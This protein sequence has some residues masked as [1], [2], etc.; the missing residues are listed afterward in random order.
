M[1]K[2]PDKEYYSPSDFL[3]APKYDAHIHY[4]TFDDSFVRK[5]SKANI[6]LLSINT[7]FNVPIDTQFEV[8][9]SLHQ[10]HP[11]LFNFLCTFDASKFNAE[12]FAEDSIER[13]KLCVAAG[14]KGVKM[15]KNIGMILKNEVGKY[16]MADDPVFEPIFRYLE[17]EKIPLLA[18]FGDTRNCWLPFE[19]MTAC[20]DV[21]YY[22]NNPVYHI[23][24]QPN[25]PT[26]EQII[27]AR[28]NILERYPK[29]VFI[30]A[31]L[32]GME[33]SLEQIAQ[34]FEQFPNFYVDLS[35]C[36]SHI[37]IH[38]LNDRKQVIDFFEKYSDRILYG[39]DWYVSKYN[40]RAWLKYFC[41]FFP[42]LYMEMLFR[43]MC[44]KFKQHWLFLATDM[45]IE[46]GKFGASPDSPTQMKGL[47][48]SKTIVDRIFFENAHAVYLRK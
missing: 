27:T 37:F 44:H 9:Q 23:Y 14:A 40:K 31:H 6:A 34:R 5:A 13:I 43:Y 18:H 28:D 19:E 46:T 15:W 22:M 17:N 26:Y 7:D 2:K 3:S 45:T 10:R 25:A 33:W 35:A 20:H 12:T 24:N 30:G 47:Q 42:K 4:H 21:Q 32:G 41:K 39:S 48:L 36:I 38:T 29:L 8:S 16:V 1:E 11:N